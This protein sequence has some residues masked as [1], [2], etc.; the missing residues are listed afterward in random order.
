MKANIEDLRDTFKIGYDAYKESRDEADEVWDLYHNRQ[1]TDEQ[2]AILAKRGQPAETFNVIKMFSRMI[3]GYYSTIVNTAV[4]KPRW[5]RDVTTASVLNDIIAYTFKQNRINTVEGDKIKLGAL[6]SGLLVSY[7][8][9]IP[10]KEKDNYG[11]TINKI[12]LS[13]VPDCEIIMDPL[14]RA[15]DY[16]DARFLHRFRWLPKE[17]MIKLFGKEKVRLLEE[18]YNFLEAPE[19]DF[20]YLY[21]DRFVGKYR[22]HDNYLIV[23]TVLV[24]DEGKRWSCYWSDETLLKKEEITFKT[25]KWPYRVQRVNSSD[26]T[27]YY[28]AFREVIQSQHAI[29]QAV[30]KIQLLANSRRAYVQKEAVE[31]MADFETAFNRVSG[32]IPVLTLAGIKLDEMSTDIQ[33]QYIIVDKALDRIQKVLGVNDS[34]LGMAFASDSGRKVKLQQQATIM[35]LRYMTSRVESWFEMLADDTAKLAQQYYKAHQVLSITDEITGQRWVELNRPIM[36][37]TGE[38]DQV[39]GQPVERAVLLPEVDPSNGDFMEDEDG[40]IMLGPVSTEDSD[41]AYTQ[42]EIEIDASAYNDDDERSQL[43]VETVMGGQVGAMIMQVNPAGFFKMASLSIRNMKSRYSP[44]IAEVLDQT[45]Q[46]LQ[47]NPAMNQQI[48][49]A[50]QGSAGSAGQPG[51]ETMSLPDE[52]QSLNAG[53]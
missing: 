36:E 34:F 16:S 1:F 17:S 30:L 41:F 47:G 46:M 4:V 23:H 33:S 31:N 5:P 29:N 45:A 3:V 44:E 12:E 6:I 35:S 37:Q 21:N 26:K 32:V 39:T 14:S 40:N 7:A 25:V 52:S 24:D 13:Y 42:F 8:D 20:D 43:L 22:V 15:D 49:Q 9:V 27:E 10:T 11:R 19:A 48:A 28:G 51:S 38:F 2:L 18:Y 53:V 50:N